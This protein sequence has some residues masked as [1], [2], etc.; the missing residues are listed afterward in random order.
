MSTQGPTMEHPPAH[1]RALPTGDQ[2][3]TLVALGEVSAGVDELSVL[4]RQDGSVFSI[5]LDSRE[6]MRAHAGRWSIIPTSQELLLM[7]RIEGPQAKRRATRIPIAGEVEAIGGLADV[8]AMI[9]QQSWS[10]VLRVVHD[11]CPYVGLEAQLREI[12][13]NEG[14]VR[15]GRSNVPEDR[16]GEILYRYGRIP[17]SAVHAAFAPSL[18]ERRIGESLIALGLI[19]GD[20]L[21]EFLKKQT[22]EIFFTLLGMKRG[23]YWFE[24]AGSE[25]EDASLDLGL[26]TQRLLM[27]GA[28]LLDELEHYRQ[29]IP[30]SR[31]VLV[32]GEFGTNNIVPLGEI[33]RRTLR[34]L[35]GTRT[36]A[37]IGRELEIGE[38][39]AT[40]VLH[41]LMK[42]GH[43]DLD[44]ELDDGSIETRTDT[45]ER[46]IEIVVRGELRKAIMAEDVDLEAALSIPDDEHRLRR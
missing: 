15:S 4:V 37:D 43:A 6:R 33:A 29:L 40:R 35:D 7:R 46:Q 36:V 34:L 44:V 11:A 19:D 17:R 38:L 2:T 41:G 31:C 10:G 5:D 20:E 32:P 39:E 13:F 28:R 23:H 8:I 16:L 3:C 24:L 42:G 25:G 12:R 21:I 45:E 1:L 30:S 18:G 9:H 22:E 14:E 27:E 26:M